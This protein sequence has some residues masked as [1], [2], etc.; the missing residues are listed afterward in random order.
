MR[1]FVALFLLIVVAACSAR[2][3]PLASK[4]GGGANPSNGDDA[5][6]DEVESDGGSVSSSHDAATPKGDAANVDGGSAFQEITAFG[7]NPGNLSMFVHVPDAL[8]AHDVPVVV[9]LHGCLHTAEAYVNEVGWN[10]VADKEK[11]IGLYPQTTDNQACFAWYDPAQARRD[12]G[13]ALSIKQMIDYVKAH[14]PV[15]EVYVTGASSGGAMTSVMLA[16]YPD[17]FAAGAVMSAVPFQCSNTPLSMTACMLATQPYG[18]D[19][20]AGL[21]RDAAPTPAHYPRVSVWH[22]A[23][24]QAASPINAT[25]IVAGWNE[26]H[27]ISQSPTRTWT[28]GPANY[29]QFADANGNVQVEEWIIGNMGHAV[30]IDPSHGCGTPTKYMVDVG[31]CSTTLA[32]DFFFRR[33]HPNVTGPGAPWNCT[34]SQVDNVAHTTAKRAAACPPPTLDA[35]ALGS[36]DDLGLMAITETSWVKQIAYGYYEAG[37]CP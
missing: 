13:Q 17:V 12:K 19:E 9:V 3:S 31:L 37:R 15:G 28:V 11:F 26:V 16:T 14:Y 2:S 35:C 23:A 24:D 5:T 21:I 6:S 36:G 4:G 7:S 33:P 8:P 25:E 27:G 32:L 22:G 18:K 34:E 20:W 29:S 10:D 1:G 30:A